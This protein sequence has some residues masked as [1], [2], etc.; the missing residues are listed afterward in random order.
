[1]RVAFDIGSVSPR[2]WLPPLLDALTEINERWLRAHPEAPSIYQGGVRYS[3]EP[4]GSELWRTLP[5]LLRE[6][7]GDCE[8]LACA[9][10]AELRVGGTPAR[11][12]PLFVSRSRGRVGGPAVDLIHIV[13]RHPDGTREDPSTRLGM[14]APASAG[15]EWWR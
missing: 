12:V 14:N 6:R 9:R 3:A 15:A 1:M 7:V 2:E 4:L 11:A 5:V 10:A 8:D 13:V